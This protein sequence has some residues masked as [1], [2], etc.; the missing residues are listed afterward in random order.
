MET[1]SQWKYAMTSVSDSPLNRSR[2]RPVLA[3]YKPNSGSKEQVRTYLKSL[4]CMYC[5]SMAYK[6]TLIPR[7]LMKCKN[8]Q[9]ESYVNVYVTLK[10]VKV[11]LDASVPLFS[12]M[13]NIFKI[14]HKNPWDLVSFFYYYKCVNVWLN[15]YRWNT[16]RQWSRIADR[17]I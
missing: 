4:Q 9:F 12:L 8:V 5:R 6:T 2:N 1:S 16:R 13:W 11:N 3:R 10:F 7:F 17:V 14:L 15:G